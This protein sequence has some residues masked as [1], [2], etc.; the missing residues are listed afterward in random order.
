MSFAFTEVGITRHG[1]S[2]HVDEFRDAPLDLVVTVWGDAVEKR[3]VW[4]GQE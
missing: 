2:K 4:L 3:P 1:R